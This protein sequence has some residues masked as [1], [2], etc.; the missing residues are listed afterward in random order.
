MR[1]K[2]DA[3]A[4]LMEADNTKLARQFQGQ[5]SGAKLAQ[6]SGFCSLGAAQ[7][8][9]FEGGLGQWLFNVHGPV[10]GSRN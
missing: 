7:S 8:T 6:T 2:F 3:A 4:T 1:R 9:D 10:E 5:S